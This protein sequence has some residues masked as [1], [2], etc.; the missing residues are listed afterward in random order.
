M[1]II[2]L[3]PEDW[4][5]LMTILSQSRA[6]HEA[7]LRKKGWDLVLQQDFSEHTVSHDEFGS[8]IK[9][10]RRTYM[11]RGGENPACEHGRSC[12]DEPQ[13]QTQK[14]ANTRQ[15]AEQAI[16]LRE[17]RFSCHWSGIARNNSVIPDLNHENE[18][19]AVI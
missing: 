16:D 4:P 12:M 18:C 8:G 14:A 2:D 1:S 5:G 10:G 3:H 17:K 19:W 9:S 11:L 13:N 6:L 15:M 7:F